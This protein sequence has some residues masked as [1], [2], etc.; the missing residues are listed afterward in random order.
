MY[1]EQDVDAAEAAL[2]ACA[3]AQKPA[4]HEVLAALQA[5]AGAVEQFVVGHEDWPELQRARRVIAR[6]R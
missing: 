3:D 2:L 6:A 1:T 5:L 4:A